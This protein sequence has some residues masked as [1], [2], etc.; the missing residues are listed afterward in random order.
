VR[1]PFRRFSWA[2]FCLGEPVLL[3]VDPRG[4]AV[5]ALRSAYK[6]TMRFPGAPTEEIEIRWYETTK[7]FLK[8]PTVYNSLNWDNPHDARTHT[9]GEVF[10]A[11]RPWC[12][13]SGPGSTGPA[14]PQGDPAAWL[15]ETDSTSP[16]F[17]MGAFCDYSETITEILDLVG[18]IGEEIG[19]EFE[20]VLDLESS[21]GTGEGVLA[22]LDVEIEITSLDGTGEGEAPVL[23]LELEIEGEVLDI[24]G[25]VSDLELEIEGTIATDSGIAIDFAVE[26][27]G[28]IATEAE[29]NLEVELTAVVT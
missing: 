25:G 13:G 2:A 6:T 10:G 1:T 11:P 24:I 14:P 29:N 4:F 17:L 5:E 8:T 12:N 26:I 21:E 18:G 22:D 3:P 28:E 20:V 19:G 23:D 9:A 7:P 16:M 27:E 15:G